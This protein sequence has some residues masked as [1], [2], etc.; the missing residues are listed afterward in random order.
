MRII[1]LGSGSSGNASI[2]EAGST[3][4]MLD[5]GFGVRELE[6]RCAQCDIDPTTIN[7]VLVTHEHSDHAG[8]VLRFAANYQLPVYLTAGTWIMLQKKWHKE[9]SK[10]EQIQWQMIESYEDFNLG[11]IQVCPLPVPHDAREPC[12]FT[13]IAKGKKLGV[14]TDLGMITPHVIEKYQAC[15]GLFLECNH[16]VEMLRNGEYPPSLKRR[17]GGSYGHL[18]NQQAADFL[19][20]IEL[21]R[22]QW[23]VAV[24]I[25]QQNNTPELALSSLQKHW[26]DLSSLS[27]AEQDCISPWYELA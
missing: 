9:A 12:Q 10:F 23:L 8:G 5:C 11:D 16:D 20:A 26:Q 24:H 7:A 27:V 2:I 1:T 17:V 25:S 14:L 18:N 13:F 4:L 6:R 15:D 19:G 3:R 21:E 22:L